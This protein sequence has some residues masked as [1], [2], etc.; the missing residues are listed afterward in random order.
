VAGGAGAFL[1]FVEA[2]LEGVFLRLVAILSDI[3]VVGVDG[4]G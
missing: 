2:V 1:V 3:I 4:N